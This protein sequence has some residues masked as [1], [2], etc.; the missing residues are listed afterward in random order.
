MVEL[1]KV[2]VVAFVTVTQPAQEG[3]IDHTEKSLPAMLVRINDCVALLSVVR[4]QI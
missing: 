2:T 4:G 1:I 3:N